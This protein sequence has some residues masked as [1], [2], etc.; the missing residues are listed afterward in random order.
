MGHVIRTPIVPSNAPPLKGAD[1][2]MPMLEDGWNDKHFGF[3]PTRTC[4]LVQDTEELSDIEESGFHNAVPTNRQLVRQYQAQG[5]Q[6]E[7][8]DPRN[9]REQ[10]AIAKKLA[11][12]F[13]QC[14]G[15]RNYRKRQ[16]KEGKGKEEQ[17][18]PDHLEEAF[19]RALVRWP[20]VGRKKHSPRP[21]M[22]AMGRNEL[23]S[24]Y[25][26]QLTGELRHRKQISSHIQ[27]LKEFVRIE[28][29][30]MCYL[31]SA[32]YK[33]HPSR[34]NAALARRQ[35]STYPVTSHQ[36]FSPNRFRSSRQAHSALHEHLHLILDE[37]QMYIRT[38]AQT[39]HS[40]PE[41]VH[42]YTSYEPVS[43]G[44]G[45]NNVVRSIQMKDICELWRI[46]PCIAM[47]KPIRPQ[48]G[49]TL[50]IDATLS[51]HD[52]Q[53]VCSNPDIELAIS[54]AF[55][56]PPV[57]TSRAATASH[58][59]PNTSLP[60][61]ACRTKIYINGE[62][63]DP[64]D[65]STG[66]PEPAR[67]DKV[68]VTTV[69]DV[70]QRE[71]RTEYVVTNFRS[72][73]W[74]GLFW[75]LA[76]DQQTADI[77]AS[78]P[79]AEDEHETLEA[80]RTQVTRI[81]EAVEEEINS[82]T[83][84]QDI[85]A[86]LQ[87]DG[88]DTETVLTIFW[89]FQLAKE[90]ERGRTT[91]DEIVIA[92]SASTM[93]GGKKGQGPKARREQ[94]RRLEADRNRAKSQEVPN[95]WQQYAQLPQNRSQTV[96]RHGFHTHCENNNP[97]SYIYDQI[98]SLDHV[99][100]GAD[101]TLNPFGFSSQ[102][103][104]ESYSGQYLQQYASIM[105]SASPNGCSV[106]GSSALVALKSP[107]FFDQQINE[108]ADSDAVVEDVWPCV[109]AV[110]PY[111]AVPAQNYYQSFLESMQYQRPS[112]YSDSY[113]D[114]GYRAT[115]AGNG[116]DLPGESSV[117]ITLFPEQ[118]QHQAQSQAIPTSTSSQNQSHGGSI[119]A[120]SMEDFKALTA[121]DVDRH[122]HTT[123][124]LLLEPNVRSTWNDTTDKHIVNPPGFQILP[125][126]HVAQ[127]ITSCINREHDIHSK[128]IGA[129]GSDQYGI[130]QL[131][132]AQQAPLKPG[133]GP[134]DD[135]YKDGLVIH[136]PRPLRI[137]VPLRSTHGQIEQVSEAR[138]YRRQA[139]AGAASWNTG[140]ATLDEQA[141]QFD[142]RTDGNMEADNEDA[143]RGVSIQHSPWGLHGQEEHELDHLSSSRLE[144]S[145]ELGFV[146][147]TTAAVA[148]SYRLPADA[149]ALS[150]VSPATAVDSPTVA[151]YT[152]AYSQDHHSYD[153]KLIVEEDSVME[154]NPM[155]NN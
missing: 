106:G 117:S 80:R 107:M 49:R 89:T 66:M 133:P 114:S 119:M 85:V 42:T 53:Q 54:F 149:L 128:Y 36:L 57:S 2:Q 25:I 81:R 103:S 50:H 18:W 87:P 135:Q 55:H 47:L 45:D 1:K 34:D 35:A 129:H 111:A 90:G 79:L 26:L 74:A 120:T 7:R 24:D 102:E 101:A 141:R 151:D 86:S 82:V 61:L 29:D 37:F 27:T 78:T 115:A 155:G 126:Q 64:L 134:H 137:N 94:H 58:P 38:P 124:P 67:F 147:T 123:D 98:S 15:Y 83:A 154:D 33:K 13:A 112:F 51:L 32:A 72:V 23:I 121:S 152:L 40:G 153:A 46:H 8:Y 113:F 140:A 60:R 145:P 136:Q 30:I 22:K 52:T 59:R 21:G 6:Y 143:I 39:E 109:G 144:V 20:P 44:N 91:C 62:L 48:T 104:S 63:E 99:N 118:D 138:R 127:G 69:D 5:R 3:P 130:M 77:L 71:S 70:N 10:D 105:K 142:G 68:D 148:E 110:L 131:Q 56:G 9:E 100:V 97:F 76:R 116:I 108:G 43:F 96:S 139:F 88:A 41:I 122:R 17:K 95:L 31:S 12:L 14:E 65:T 125:S 93:S 11:A 4:N 75:R 92:P 19:L 146:A 28:P 16:P 132:Q 150:V 73:F 84:V